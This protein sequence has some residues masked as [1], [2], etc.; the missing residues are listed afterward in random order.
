MRTRTSN[1]WKVKAGGF[2]AMKTRFIDF[3]IDYPVIHCKHIDFTHIVNCNNRKHFSETALIS[4]FI[5]DYHLERYWNKPDYYIR[6]WQSVA[7]IMSPD[8][9]LMIGMPDPMQRWQV[10]RNRFLG[11][12]WQKAGVNVVPTICWSD[13]SSFQYCFKGVA[14]QS[15]I[16]ISS[17][18]MISDW[19]LPYF[20]AGYS[21]MLNQLNPSKILFMASKK[22]RHLFTD[23]RI[24]WLDSFFEHRRKQLW[25]NEQV[26]D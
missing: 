8:F 7:G 1:N 14:T 12:L 25:Q 18:G 10:Y 24:Q 5:D 19:Q 17:I 11:Y 9:T 22:Y 21:E 4:T 13:E 2:D 15:V 6:H 26:K 20:M 3:D 16:A 23:E